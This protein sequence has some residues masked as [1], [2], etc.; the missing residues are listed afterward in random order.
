MANAPFLRGLV[1]EDVGLYLFFL[2][3]YELVQLTD[4]TQRS[5]EPAESHTSKSDCEGRSEK[6]KKQLTVEV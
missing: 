2:L 4:G 6:G 5:A 3:Q 1:D